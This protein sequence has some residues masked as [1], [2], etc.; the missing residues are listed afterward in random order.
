MSSLAWGWPP[1]LAA[2]SALLPSASSNVPPA[3]PQGEVGDPGQKGAK[4]N[5][6]EHV[7]VHSSDLSPLPFNLSPSRPRPCLGVSDSC[8]SPRAPLGPPDP[9]G[10][11]DSLALR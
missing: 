1:S 2:P 9:S 7:S 11:W 3:L 10:P 5:K 8:F 4:G 6:G